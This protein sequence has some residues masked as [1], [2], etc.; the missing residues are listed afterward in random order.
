M[1]YVKVD[2]MHICM[3][4]YVYIDICTPWKIQDMK[5]EAFGSSRSF[6]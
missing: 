4:I 6:F 5:N 3:Y 1:I 2:I